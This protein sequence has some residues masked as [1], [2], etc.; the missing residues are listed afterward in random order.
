MEFVAEPKIDGMAIELVY[1]DGILISGSTRGDGFIGEDVTKNIMYI[2]DIPKKLYE[3]IEYLKVRGEIFI[4]KENA[5]DFANTRNAVAGSVRQLDPRVTATRNLEAF[6]YTIVEGLEVP[7]QMEALETLKRLGFKT[8]HLVKF[9]E[10]ISE[11]LNFFKHLN[12]IRDEIYYEIDGMVIKVNDVSSQKKLGY[13]SN[14]PRWAIAY[15]F[16]AKETF[17]TI[18]GIN[19]QVGKTGVLTPVAELLPVELGGVTIKSATLHNENEIKRKGIKVGDIVL[20]KRAGDVIPE[21]VKVT[22]HGNGKDFVMPNFCPVCGSK[23]IKEKVFSRCSNN[24]C[25]AQLKGSIIHFASKSAMNI[26]G[27][28]PKIIEQLIEKE[29]ISDPI[30]LYFL[31]KKDLLNLERMGEKLVEK[32]I[33]SINKSKNTTLSRLIYALCI[34]HVGEYIADTLSINFKSLDDLRSTNEQELTKIPGIGPEIARSI[35][36]FFGSNDELFDKIKQASIVYKSKVSNRLLGKTF[37]FTGKLSIS[38][39]QAKEMVENLGGSVSSSLSRK[40]NYLITGEKCGLKLDNAKD[41][42]III[43]NENEFLDIVK[44]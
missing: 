29:I 9:C 7:T 24:F 11:A 10:D 16:P 30:D 14:Y 20:I 1:R 3:N 37:V 18:V 39:S 12:E 34:E 41:F 8:N 32:I 36:L 35:M 6:F 25:P 19:V 27:L 40:T 43:L 23:V 15:K 28:G 38:R 31:Q 42:D 21:V 22:Y 2:E 5:K 4:S 17:T 33:T 44:L 26:D 13:T